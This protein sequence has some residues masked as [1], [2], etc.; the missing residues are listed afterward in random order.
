MIKF[1]QHA[2]ISNECKMPYQILPANQKEAIGKCRASEFKDNLIA[3]FQERR[4][5]A[6]STPY[7]LEVPSIL[8]VAGHH[9]VRYL[10][11]QQ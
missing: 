8:D 11:T 7:I 6:N 4:K 2:N 9:H 3:F 5:L 1:P 10:T